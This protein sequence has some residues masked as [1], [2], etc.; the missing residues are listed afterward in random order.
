MDLATGARRWKYTAGAIIGE[1]SP[2]VGGGLVFFGDLGGTVH[3]VDISDGKARWTF[4]TGG[5]VK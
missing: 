3:A 2:A 4:K 1:S 5:E